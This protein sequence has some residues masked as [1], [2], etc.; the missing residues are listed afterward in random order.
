MPPLKGWQTSRPA[1][2]L[3]WCHLAAAHRGLAYRRQAGSRPL[4]LRGLSALLA[5][6]PRHGRVLRGTSFDGFDYDYCKGC[7]ICAEVCPTDAITMVPE[8]TPV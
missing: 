6:L 2:S 7:E 3:A 5:P 4:E 1:A 8:V